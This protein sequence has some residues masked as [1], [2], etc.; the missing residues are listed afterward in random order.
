MALAPFLPQRSWKGF[1]GNPLDGIPAP[2]TLTITNHLRKKMKELIQTPDNT[3][4]I[5]N[6]A[7][8]IS[9]PKPRRRTP[10]CTVELC[11]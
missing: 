10:H 2:S 1:P 5:Q 11:G 8:H 9:C 7:G 6:A 4:N 3:S